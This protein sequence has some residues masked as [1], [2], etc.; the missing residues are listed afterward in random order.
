M[1]LN[2]LSLND[3]WFAAYDTSEKKRVP[4]YCDRVVFRDSFDGNGV[5]QASKLSH[6]AKVSV[7]AYV[8]TKIIPLLIKQPKRISNSE[9]L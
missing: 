4:A 2:N 3:W 9:V 6:P 7:A 5:V 1:M 8:V